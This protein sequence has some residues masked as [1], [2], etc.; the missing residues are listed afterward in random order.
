MGK[1]N[2]KQRRQKERLD[3]ELSAKEELMRRRAER[4]AINNTI[5]ESNA[6]T[7]DYVKNH[8]TGELYTAMAIILRRHPYRWSAEKTM[9]YVGAVAAIINDLNERTICDADLVTEGEKWGI[10]V[11]WNANHKYIT[12]LG[13]FEE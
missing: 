7:E 10:R 1:L 13:I 3:R 6:D 4:D 8:I 5:N 2:R 9:R 12:D 11:R